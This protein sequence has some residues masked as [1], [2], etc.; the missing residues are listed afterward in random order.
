MAGSSDLS[1]RGFKPGILSFRVSCLLGSKP[2]EVS[3]TPPRATG[4]DQ[5]SSCAAR[6]K[7]EKAE[8]QG[9]WPHL[10]EA[11]APHSRTVRRSLASPHTDHSSSIGIEAIGDCK[12]LLFGS[13]KSLPCPIMSFISSSTHIRSSS[14]LVFL[15]RSIVADSLSVARS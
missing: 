11:L 9:Y 10:R 7:F 2:R 12:V 8:A 5:N 15:A 1:R 3:R 6:C 4:D 13:A 14:L